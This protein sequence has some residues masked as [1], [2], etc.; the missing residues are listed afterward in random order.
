M[1]QQ[2]TIK[3]SNIHD[4]LIRSV[5]MPYTLV[6]QEERR[7]GEINPGYLGLYG[8]VPTHTVGT[9]HLSTDQIP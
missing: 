7:K 2:K 3:K 1:S 9:P 8:T 5:A 6:E 4:V